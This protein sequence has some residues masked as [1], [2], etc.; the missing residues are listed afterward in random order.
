MT[1]MQNESL[2]GTQQ[3]QLFT[4]TTHKK[5]IKRVDPRFLAVDAKDL[6]IGEVALLLR[7]LRRVVTALDEA[8]GFEEH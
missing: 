5:K 1:D 6:R 4:Q 3:R 2:T 7:E 8:G